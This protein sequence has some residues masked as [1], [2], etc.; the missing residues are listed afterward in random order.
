M[1][2]RTVHLHGELGRLFGKKH[3]LAVATPSEAVSALSANRKGFRQYFWRKEAAY[4]FVRGKSVKRGTM[5]LL[6]ELPMLL[7]KED[8]HIVPATRGAG[9]GGGKGVGMIVLGAV[10]VA[11]AFFT[12]GAS[13]GLFGAELATS[14]GG[15]AA[16]DATMGLFSTGLGLG[17][18]VAGLG[19][20]S[21]G[22][23]GMLGATMAVG[24]ISQLITPTP[25][26][27][28]GTYAAM[29]APNARVS[30]LYN[31]PANTMEQGGPVPMI[32]GRM[33]VGSTLLSASLQNDE[34]N[35]STY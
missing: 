3:R 16:A 15:V 5:M 29:E 25:Q 1:Q 33:R 30:F 22:S 8:F 20:M 12:G 32:Y 18:D 21:A 17:A 13:L 26:A 6:Q 19:L 34:V 23:L 11:G 28:A 7:G 9:G 4:T 31:G 2:L 35:I 14:V 27:S 10:A 24:G